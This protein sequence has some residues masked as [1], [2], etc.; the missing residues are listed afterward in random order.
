M[1]EFA[2][3]AKASEIPVGCAKVFE[4]NGLE[5]AVFNREGNYY[6]VANR[7]THSGGPLV[8][9][10]VRDNEVVCPWHGAKFELSSGKA[11][12]SPSVENVVSYRLRLVDSDL[13]I[14]L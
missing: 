12:C 14:E 5:I 4:V 7:C 9:G 10:R 8:L 13:E 11:V 3:L 1:P 6:A 2:F